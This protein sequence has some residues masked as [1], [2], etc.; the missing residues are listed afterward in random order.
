MRTI[1]IYISLV[2]LILCSLNAKAQHLRTD[3]NLVGHVVD[4]NGEHIPFATVVLKNTTVGT[5]TDETGHYRLINMPLGN[6]TVVAT[7][8]GYKPFSKELEFKENHTI[9]LKIVLEQDVLGLEEVVVTADRNEKNRKDASVIVNTLTPKLFE[10]AQTATISD[11]LN[12]CPGLRMENNCQNCG[13]S[14]VRMNGMEGPYSQILINSRPIFSGLAGVYGLEL[15]PSNMIERME[16]IRGGGS[17][18]YGSNA[19]AGTINLILKDP[20]NNS[21]EIGASSGYTGVGIEGGDNPAFDY[22]VNFNTSL[23]SS[24][25]RTGMALYG[26]HRDHEPYDANSDGFSEI[27]QINN[28]TVGTRVFHRFTHRNKLAVDFFTIN[29]DRRGGNKFEFLKHEA[30]IAEAVGHKITTGAVTFDQFFRESDKLSTFISAQKVD[31]DSYYG[32]EQ[33][34]KDYGR[35][36]GLT[37]NM[38]A[39]YTA[40]FSSSNLI[41]GIEFKGETL[42]DKK[43][44]YPDYENAEMV[45]N[46]VVIP[47]T[48][49]TLVADQKSTIYGAF[50]QYEH[51]FNQ[52]SASVG[53]R[54]DHYEIID[55]INGHDKSGDVL[56]PRITLKYD[57]LDIIQTRASYSQGYRAPQIFDEDLHIET[58][59]SRKVIH[60]NDPDLKQETSHSYMLSFDFNKKLGKVNTGFLLEGFYTEL[61][62]A[63]ANEYGNPDEN[64]VVTYTRV[65]ATGGAMVSGIN[66]ELNIIPKGDFTFSGGF[67]IQQSKYEEV[68][69]FGEKDFFRTPNNYGYLTVDWDFYKGFCFLASGTYTGS[70]LVPYFGTELPEGE[71]RDAGELR[72]SDPFYDLG[73]KLSYKFRLNGAKMQMFVGMKNVFNSYQDDFDTGI[74]RDPGY[75]YGPSLPRTFY[76]GIKIGN[77]L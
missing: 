69:E 56:S 61:Q 23:V 77:L 38:G 75:L 47:H 41:G 53:L 39:Q 13:F 20:V 68:Q 9:E 8:V 46:E 5:A 14:Q 24:D 17:A 34:L 49:N 11:G 63:F 21:Y 51:R 42:E 16:V 73:V 67:T 54:Y 15:I 66:M 43:L 36:E 31:R 60:E 52:F 44:G 59:G 71:I 30:D 4:T 48:E 65:N 2:L 10:V 1:T 26:Y 25:S 64:G 40:N 62:D 37:Y 27:T 74:N 50:T 6:F 57:I 58:S 33:S 45:G 7:S 28:V 3:A 76:F 55:D 72:E 29:E 35:T 19:I 22:N 70:M 18:L 12:Y 32:A